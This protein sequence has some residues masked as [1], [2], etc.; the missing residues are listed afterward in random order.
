VTDVRLQLTEALDEVERIAQAATPGPWRYS[1]TKQ[2]LTH[3]DPG[4]RK[5]L[6]WMGAEGEEFVGA[7]PLDTPVCVAGTGPADDPQSM[8]DAAFIAGWDPATVLR[9]VAYFREELR[10]IDGE[11]ADDPMDQTALDRLSG[12]A[13]F[14]LGT[15]EGT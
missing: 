13:A 6:A 5:M 11:L 9:L 10:E 12:V 1:P 15:K 8:A 14:W 3:E 4:V 7:G 2:W